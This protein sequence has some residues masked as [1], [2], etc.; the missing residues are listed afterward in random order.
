VTLRVRRADRVAP[1]GPQVSWAKLLSWALGLP[2][3][4]YLLGAISTFTTRP[5]WGPAQSTAVESSCQSMRS[6]AE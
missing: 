1:R 4:S 3:K 2:D 5:V 6:F